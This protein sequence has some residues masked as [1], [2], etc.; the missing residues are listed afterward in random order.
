MTHGLGVVY[1][2]T[3]VQ[4]D[5][6]KHL[7]CHGSGSTHGDSDD[8][9]GFTGGGYGGGF[10][11]G[12]R[13]KGTHGMEWTDLS[14]GVVGMSKP[15]RARFVITDPASVHALLGAAGALADE[16]ARHLHPAILE[17]LDACPAHEHL[18]ALYELEAA[19]RGRVG[20]SDER[21]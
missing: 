16:I 10:L 5:P 13:D 21:A 4:G 20:G 14:G 9:H 8:R 18:A 1:F 17:K 7:L 3:N 19:L 2:R 6:T 15:S 12:G 11:N